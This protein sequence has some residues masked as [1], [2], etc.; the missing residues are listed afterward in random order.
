MILRNNECGPVFAQ[1][2]ET[3]LDQM[4]SISINGA[5]SFVKEDYLWFLQHG[6]SN[7]YTLLL[8]SRQFAEPISVIYLFIVGKYLLTLLDHQ[9]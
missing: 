6:S 3:I 5:C 8:S 2:L 1:S 7:G 4:L 9:L